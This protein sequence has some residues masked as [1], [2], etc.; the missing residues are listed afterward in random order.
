MQKTELLMGDFQ[1]KTMSPVSY[2]HSI[3][4]WRTAAKNNK[5]AENY[6]V[7]LKIFVAFLIS[8]CVQSTQNGITNGKLMK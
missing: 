3:L 5:T 8:N 2:S 4:E 6:H 7:F 1:G